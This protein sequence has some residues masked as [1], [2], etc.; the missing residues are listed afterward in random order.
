MQIG[1][2]AGLKQ[3]NNPLD[4]MRITGQ[5][6]NHVILAVSKADLLEVSVRRSQQ[7]CLLPVELCP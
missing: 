4:H 5:G 2:K 3:S 1:I 7:R 6:I